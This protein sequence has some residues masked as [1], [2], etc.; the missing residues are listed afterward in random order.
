MPSSHG[1]GRKKRGLPPGTLLHVGTRKT[2]RIKI[3]VTDYTTD[4][5]NVEE[6]S[7]I[8]K[9]CTTAE[10]NT[11]TWINI[12][13]VDQVESIAAIGKRLGIDD[14]V[15]EDIVN[16]THRPKIEEHTGYIFIILKMLHLDAESF[17]IVPEQVSL[18][19]M[20]NCLITFQEREGDVFGPVRERL[21]KEGSRIRRSGPDYLAHA[22]MDT[23]VDNYFVV[24][25]HLAEQIEEMEDAILDG[26]LGQSMLDLYSI[27]REV[28]LL[29]RLT[30]PM[31]DITSS[32]ERG[33][34]PLIR[35]ETT[36]FIKDLHDHV[37]QVMESVESSREALTSLHEVY[38]SITSNRMNE[39]MKVL[40]II[41]T[42]FIPLTF[43]AGM[44]GMNFDFMPE[45]KWPWGYPLALGGM[46]LIAAG[47]FLFFRWKKWL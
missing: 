47:M 17:R 11:T 6:T 19:L 16:T 29:R 8:D 14:L 36:K 32:L 23:V 7:D 9:L 10:A 26:T 34:S 4:R 5:I 15:L 33:D 28:I 3:T 21:K 31:R 40:T 20:E 45:L 18:I 27:R 25:E 46:G 37:I 1:M 38:L 2:E 44:Y 42:I 35:Q 12:D 39:V 24:L 41:A 13:G 43:V 22:L 30:W